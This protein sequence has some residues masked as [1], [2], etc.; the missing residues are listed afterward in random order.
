MRTLRIYYLNNNHKEHTAVSIIFI[1]L[2]FISLVLITVSL[3]LFTAFTQPPPHLW[4]WPFLL[5]S[6]WTPM[7]KFLMEGCSQMVN[8]SVTIAASPCR[9]GAYNHSALT[10]SLPLLSLSTHSSILAWRSPWTEE[11]GGLQSTGRKESDTTEQLHW[12]YPR[13]TNLCDSYGHYTSPIYTK[14]QLKMYCSF[15]HPSPVGV[16]VPNFHISL[17]QTIL[18]WTSCV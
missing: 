12:D 14:Y 11:L 13:Q 3:Y 4:S 17:L 8:E 16:R 7:I 5:A 15:Y 1:M 10:L 6:R 2:Y 18:Q 9:S